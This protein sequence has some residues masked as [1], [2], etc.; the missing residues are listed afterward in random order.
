MRSSSIRCRSTPREPSAQTGCKAR[1]GGT[2]SKTPEGMVVVHRVGKNHSMSNNGVGASDQNHAF[3]AMRGEAG[4]GDMKRRD[5]LSL[6][7]GAVAAWPQ[8]APAQTTPQAAAQN[9]PQR[10]V[11]IIV[12]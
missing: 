5:F 10:V 8:R 1:S 6:M 4:S 12:P 3:E 9:W 7:G 11:R 2:E